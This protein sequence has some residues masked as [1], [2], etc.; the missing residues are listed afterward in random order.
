MYDSSICIGSDTLDPLANTCVVNNIFNGGFFDLEL[1][2]GQIFSIIKHGSS[3]T[4]GN[5]YLFAVRLYQTPNLVEQ[6]TVLT[7]Y[8]PV[9]SF[10]PENLITNLHS[11]SASSDFPPLIDA[12]GNPSTKSSC[13]QVLIS[14]ITTEGPQYV[15][16]LDFGVSKF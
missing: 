9:I 16:G 4:K 11:R 1:T 15:F 6:A 8:S 2:E 13:F 3:P 10:E 5:C 7:D 12:A 14:T